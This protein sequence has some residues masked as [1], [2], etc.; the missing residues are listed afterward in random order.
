MEDG[1]VYGKDQQPTLTR[2]VRKGIQESDVFLAIAPPDG[3]DAEES[4]EGAAQIRYAMSLHKS[5]LMLLPSGR[6]PLPRWITDY[7]DLVVAHE[8]EEAVALIREYLELS[9]YETVGII[10]GAWS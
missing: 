1:M 7:N 4:S 2:Q 8:T 6:P 5:V 9:E 3:F 10:D